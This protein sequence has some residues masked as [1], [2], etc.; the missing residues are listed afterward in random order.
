MFFGYI[1]EYELTEHPEEV[2]LIK[3][4]NMKCSMTVKL[5]NHISNDISQCTNLKES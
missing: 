3:S 1:P 2:T 4:R 5:A